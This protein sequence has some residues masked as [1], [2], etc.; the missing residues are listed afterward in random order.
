MGKQPSLPIAQGQVE[1]TVDKTAPGIKQV[2]EGKMQKTPRAAKAGMR[3]QGLVC[4]AGA[5]AQSS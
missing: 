2:Q 3:Q 4:R 1:E 5:V